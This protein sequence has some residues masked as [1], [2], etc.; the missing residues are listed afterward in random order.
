MTHT[1]THVNLATGQ[2]TGDVIET[3]DVQ[4]PQRTQS[5]G[6]CSQQLLQWHYP[7][8][9]PGVYFCILLRTEVRHIRS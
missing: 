1:H 8:T 9:L 2:V 3:A 7:V 4:H 5:T 6:S